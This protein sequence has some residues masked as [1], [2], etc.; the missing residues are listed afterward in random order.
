VDETELDLSTGVEGTGA[1]RYDFVTIQC[2]CIRGE[3]EIISGP[4]DNPEHNYFEIFSKNV[5]YVRFFGDR[6]YTLQ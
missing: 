6:I 4:G 5:K 2:C 3:F 1:R